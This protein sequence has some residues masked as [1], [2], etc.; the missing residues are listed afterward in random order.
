MLVRWRVWLQGDSDRSNECADLRFTHIFFAILQN[1]DFVCD[2]IINNLGYY[3]KITCSS[4]VAKN[5]MCYTFVR[6][7]NYFLDLKL[8]WYDMED[9]CVPCDVLSNRFI[10]R[11]SATKWFKP[12]IPDRK[13]FFDEALYFALT[14]I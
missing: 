2:L 14:L 10:S 13:T 12:V 8:S 5:V 1:G 3:L 4:T 11:V 6:I 9:S 7:V